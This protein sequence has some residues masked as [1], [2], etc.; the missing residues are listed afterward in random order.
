MIIYSE[1]FIFVKKLD[2]LFDS[3]DFLKVST[4]RD[5]YPGFNKGEVISYLF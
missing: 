3:V 1:H 4:E 2:F 5:I